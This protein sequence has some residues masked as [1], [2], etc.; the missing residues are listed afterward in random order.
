M[1]LRLIKL[2]GTMLLNIKMWCFK[3]LTLDN[4]ELII[5]LIRLDYIYLSYCNGN[6]KTNKEIVLDAVNKYGCTLEYAD[7]S[8]K[9]CR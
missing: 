7:E 8:L 9:Q 6:I 4:K 3:H 5:E 1:V 2:F